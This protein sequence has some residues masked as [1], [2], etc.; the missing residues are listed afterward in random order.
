M[1]M[2]DINKTKSFYSE[3]AMIGDTCIYCEKEIIE[4]RLNKEI[5]I[6]EEHKQLKELRNKLTNRRVAKF[7]INGR[8]LCICPE[9]ISKINEE[10]QP[11][12][13]EENQP[14]INEENQSKI[15]KDIQSKK[16]K[17]NQESE[18]KK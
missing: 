9:C 12:T 16:I 17:K 15:N 2:Y 11:K 1:A 18:D 4:K 7:K 13:N 8:T 14:K 6:D 5:D 10:I 3:I